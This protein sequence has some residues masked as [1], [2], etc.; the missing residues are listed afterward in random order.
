M[1]QRKKLSLGKNSSPKVSKKDVEQAL[2]LNQEVKANNQEEDIAPENRINIKVKQSPK[3]KKSP[4]VQNSSQKKNVKQA[5]HKGI[6]R[7]Q[8]N[9]D[10]TDEENNLENIENNGVNL[11]D[12]RFKGLQVEDDIDQD[13]IGDI[14]DEDLDDLDIDELDDEDQQAEKEKNIQ[15]ALE[16]R[17]SQNKKG[18]KYVRRDS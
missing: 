1:D 14:D 3:N 9:E 17:E 15:K 12:E 5:Q 2:A 8:E 4:S 13:D 16:F 7:P 11:E 10:A 6:K 18:R